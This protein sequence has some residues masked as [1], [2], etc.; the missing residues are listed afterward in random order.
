M[1][2]TYEVEQHA[3]V[4]VI[5]L[6]GELTGDENEFIEAATGLLRR[7]GVVLDLADVP[8]MNSMGLGELVRIVAQGNVQEARVVLASP[9]PFVAGVFQTTQLDRY[10]EIRPTLDAA[11][12]VLRP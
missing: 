9:S 6:H 2:L 11:V 4:P 3:E 8:F 5:R 10:F 1:A 7:P 12:K